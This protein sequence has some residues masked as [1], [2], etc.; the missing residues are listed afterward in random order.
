MDIAIVARIT[1]A[2]MISNSVKPPRS[3]LA[4]TINI[5]FDLLRL[6]NSAAIPFSG[7]RHSLKVC[8]LCAFLI[9]QTGRRAR[10]N[11]FH[12]AVTGVDVKFLFLFGS[13]RRGLN[14]RHPI[15]QNQSNTT[16]FRI[17]RTGV[18]T[19]FHRA[20]ERENSERKDRDAQQHLVQSKTG[21]TA[22]VGSPTSVLILPHTLSA[23]R[24]QSVGH[25]LRSRFQRARCIERWPVRTFP[26][27]KKSIRPASSSKAQPAT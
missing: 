13:C 19:I 7:E 6:G 17:E 21:P 18:Q 24:E 12:N 25:N 1:T 14:L 26:L 22:D 9:L 23:Q 5:K 2:M 3:R 20:P 15:R 27:A 10:L 4:G 8:E 16:L 11:Q